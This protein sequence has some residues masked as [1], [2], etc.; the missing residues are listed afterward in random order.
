M[1]KSKQ[2]RPPRPARQLP[3]V[4][5]LTNFLSAHPATSSPHPTI[6]TKLRYD[7]YGTLLLLPPTSPLVTA[8]WNDY[9]SSLSSPD[10]THF[11]SSLAASFNVTH[12]AINQPIPTKE[13]KGGNLIRSPQ[14]TCLHGEFGDTNNDDFDEGFWVSTSQHGIH[15][16]WA[17]LHTMF[18]RGNITEKE[19]VHNFTRAQLES[20][21]REKDAVA[22]VDLYVGIG[23]FAFSYL[24]GGVDVV[25]GW[26]INPWSIEGCRRGAEKNKW[27]VEV[28]TKRDNVA[29]T[30]KRL[31]IYEESNEFAPQRLGDIKDATM[32]DSSAWPHIL[33]INLGL[34]PSSESAYKIAVEVLN[35][36]DSDESSWVHVHE[37]VAQ[38]DVEQRTQQ[39]ISKFKAL[40]TEAGLEVDIKCDYVEFVKSWAPGVWHCVFDIYFGR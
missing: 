39:I 18:S 20:R 21:G 9:I 4:T 16:I 28:A 37:N 27:S 38:E 24:K 14:I 33:H 36:N 13:S 25:Y 17:P 11:Y 19:R 26:D 2:K 12:I 32:R 7:I 8:P 35:L 23:Y 3:Y 30:D 10:R 6:P 34:L 5:C 1:D 22:A 40:A 29:G 31:V 15:Q